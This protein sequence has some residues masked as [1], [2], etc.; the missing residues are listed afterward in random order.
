MSLREE[1]PAY[2]FYDHQPVDQTAEQRHVANT[3]TLF[4]DFDRYQKS[5]QFDPGRMTVA[6][7][8]NAVARPSKQFST[9]PQ[10]KVIHIV[11][12]VNES[13][14]ALL[15]KKYANEGWTVEEEARL[16][17]DHAKISRLIPVE[18]GT[19]FAKLD[20]IEKQ[21]TADLNEMRKE[22]DELGL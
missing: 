3:D 17:I 20:A 10:A 18:S 7:D 1:T 12:R 22:L 16:Q 9:T 8:D 14:L 5:I 15:A 11:E 21:Q 2:S 13:R 6:T 19:A 4:L